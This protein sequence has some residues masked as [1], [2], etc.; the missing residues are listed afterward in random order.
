MS[1]AYTTFGN[2]LLLKQRSQDG[3]GTLWR[4]GEMERSGFKRIAWLRRFDN[5][6]L[7]RELLAAEAPHINQFAA[8]FRATNVVRNAVCGSSGGRSSSPGTTNPRSRS[9]RCSDAS[10]TSSSRCRPT[11]RC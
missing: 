11:T 10:S 9:T 6:A 4:A 1:A 7:D 5:P 2:F 8:G 3:L